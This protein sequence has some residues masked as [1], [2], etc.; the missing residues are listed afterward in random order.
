[1]SQNQINH[2]KKTRM[3]KKRVAKVKVEAAAMKMPVISL[4]KAMKKVK[5]KSPAMIRMK[6]QTVV[7]TK[8]PR[9]KAAKNVAKKTKTKRLKKRNHKEYSNIYQQTLF[10][11][12]QVIE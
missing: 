8:N 11:G 10:Q 9:K 6:I 4:V 5:L 1:M 2:R 7:I 3:T 12:L